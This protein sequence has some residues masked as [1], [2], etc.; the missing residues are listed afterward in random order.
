M[1]FIEYLIPLSLV[2]LVV[3]L[4]GGAL[5]LWLFMP[6]CESRKDRASPHLWITIWAFGWALQAIGWLIYSQ[7]YQR[8]DQYPK[9]VNLSK[10][11]ICLSF[12]LWIVAFS[13]YRKVRPLRIAVLLG[14]LAVITVAPIILLQKHATPP[15]DQELIVNFQNHQP[16]FNAI[17]R[18]AQVDKE[19]ESV[20]ADW[21]YPATADVSQARLDE[22]HRLFKVAGVRRCS[23]NDHKDITLE[24]WGIGS[25][26]SSDTIKGY[27]YLAKPPG[28]VVNDLDQCQPEDTRFIVEAYR[29]IE[30]N[31]YLYY[32]YIPG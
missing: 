22:Y 21:M 15:T 19:V 8:M 20:S 1:G 11:L 24:A 9:P 26:L 10:G 4:A 12:L 32:E 28:N 30:G 7:T 5:G 17:V 3:L 16:A 6:W 27:A 18:L 29:H 25:A 14:L 13:L 23:S 2:L 31:W